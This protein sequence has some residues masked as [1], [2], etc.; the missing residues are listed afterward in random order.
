MNAGDTVFVIGPGGVV[1]KVDVPFD[2][3]ARERFDSDIARGALRLVADSDVVEEKNKRWPDATRYVLRKGATPIDPA[4]L[5]TPDDETDEADGDPV[6][7]EGGDG[8]PEGPPAK[9]AGKP[10]WVAYAIS[11]GMD[12]DEADAASKADLQRAF[13]GE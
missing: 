7:D 6:D 5:V 11:Q 9:S 12:A 13:T 8:T 4:E 3:H 1:Q 2:S 10:E